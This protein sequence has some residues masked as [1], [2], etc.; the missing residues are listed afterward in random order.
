[1]TSL[2]VTSGEVSMCEQKQIT[3]TFLVV[4]AGIV[5]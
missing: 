4:F 3:G 5:A 2:P 1:M